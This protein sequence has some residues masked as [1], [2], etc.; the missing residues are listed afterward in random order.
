MSM[1]EY[2][3]A[4]IRSLL[5][6]YRFFLDGATEEERR[7]VLAELFPAHAYEFLMGLTIGA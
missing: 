3:Q 6:V 2:E 5:S 4:T 1:E 7:E